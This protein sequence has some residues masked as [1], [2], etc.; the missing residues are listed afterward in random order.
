MKR[1]SLVLLSVVMCFT[2]LCSCSSSDSSSKS[3]S[4][5]ETSKGVNDSL[6]QIFSGSEP[7]DSNRPSYSIDGNV[8]DA[9]L[10]AL[11][12]LTAD[13]WKVMN[14]DEKYDYAITILNMWM[15]YGDDASVRHTPESVVGGI[16]EYI[17]YHNEPFAA[18]LRTAAD[19]NLEKYTES[20]NKYNA[21]IDKL[22]APS[23]GQSTITTAS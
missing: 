6:L 11:R 16:N 7:N 12:N 4:K 19:N 15:Y 5:K 10:I 17:Q 3:D 21:I 9:Q 22:I 14:A 18:A 20:L 13:E 8:T 2:I 23:D 1:F